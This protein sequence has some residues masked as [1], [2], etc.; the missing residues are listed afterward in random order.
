MIDHI[1]LLLGYNLDL[2]YRISNRPSKFYRSFSIP[3][4]N[5]KKRLIK[6]PYPTLKEIQYWVL[7]NILEKNEPS[8]YAKAYIKNKT[9]SENARF[10]KGQQVV[11]K[12]DIKDFFGTI[13]FPKVYHAFYQMGYSET[14]SGMLAKLCCLNDCLPQGAPTSPYISNLISRSIDKRIGNYSIKNNLR[15]TRYS[16][17]LTLSGNIEEKTIPKII[18]MVR[19]ILQKNGF[20]IQ[21]SKLKIL[22]NSNRQSVTGI[23][24]NHK[25]S[26]CREYKKAI[27]QEVYYIQKYGLDSHLERINCQKK[28]YINHLK[29]KINWILSIE[30]KNKEFQ[31]YRELL[32]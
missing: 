19:I 4:K 14:V 31:G 25:L 6:E 15:Y 2:L 17:D 22:R 10:H 3:K 1:S 11:I 27:R 8:K 20:Q 7:N 23:V 32:K 12:I 16:D 5:G 18:H 13:K 29:G 21:K 30:K 28:N 26:V 9:L 24:V